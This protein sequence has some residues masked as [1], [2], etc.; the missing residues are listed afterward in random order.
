MQKKSLLVALFC[1]A[2]CLTGCIK[3]EE[4][5]SVAQVRIAKANELNSIADLNKAK[6]AAEAVYAQAELVV[7]QAE[8]KLR[9]AQA[10]LVN[11]QAETEKVRAELLKVKVELREVE[12]DEEKVRLQMLEADLEQKLAEVE[13][14]VAKAEADKQAWVNVLNDLIAKAELQNLRNAKAM[15][16]AEEDLENY[17]LTQ[18]GIK[19]DSAKAYSRRYFAALDE[20]QKLQYEQITTKATKALVEAGALKVRDAIHDE[21]DKIDEQIEENEAIIAILKERQTMTP[22]EAKVAVREAKL[23]LED[24]YTVRAF[25]DSVEAFAEA[26]LATL[27][28]K[29]A[30]Y[31]QGWKR[32][33]KDKF[34]DLD[35]L[36]ESEVYYGGHKTIDGVQYYGVYAYTEEEDEEPEFTPMW[37]T[38]GSY[39]VYGKWAAAETTYQRYPDIHVYEGE[40]KDFVVLTTTE[41]TPAKI[42]FEAVN[43][44]LDALAAEAKAEAAAV[45]KEE[46]EEN[47]PAR[48]SAWEEKIDEY[49]DT[50]D[51]HTKYVNERKAAIATAEK[52]YLDELAA[53]EGLDNA[54]ETAWEAFQEY[55]LVKYDVDRMLFI[56]QHEAQEAYDKAAVALTSAE[57]NLEVAIA[58]VSDE[59]DNVKTAKENEAK[60][61]GEYRKAAA[62]GIPQETINALEAT[63]QHWNPDFDPETASYGTSGNPH[64]WR[65]ENNEVAADTQNDL[66]NAQDSLKLWQDRE[67]DAQMTLWR[68][69]EGVTG[70]AAAQEAYDNAKAKRQ[71]YELKVSTCQTGANNAESMYKQAKKNYDEADK[72]IAAKEIWN[73]GFGEYEKYIVNYDSEAIDTTEYYGLTKAAGNWVRGTE[74]AGTSQAGLV[75]AV[76][77]YR[78]AV[79]DTTETA[80][81]KTHKD[82]YLA[83]KDD[84][85]EAKEALDAANAAL[86]AAIKATTNKT[87]DKIEDYLDEKAIALWDAYQAAIKEA[88]DKEHKAWSNLIKLYA[89]NPNHIGEYDDEDIE[90]LWRRLFRAQFS[91]VKSSYN[92]DYTAQI[93]CPD[94]EYHYIAEMLNEVDLTDEDEPVFTASHSLAYQIEKLQSVIDA[95]DEYLEWFEGKV[96]D[97][98][99]DVLDDIEEV[100]EGVMPYKALESSY[101]DWIDEIGK[102]ENGLNELKKAA[103]DADKEYKTAKAVYEGVKYIADGFVYV[104]VGE[105]VSGADEEGFMKLNINQAI[106]QLE[107]SNMDLRTIV[108]GLM[109]VVMLAND[110]DD[111]D[112]DRYDSDP[113]NNALV[114]IPAVEAHATGFGFG[115]MSIAELQFTKEL[116]QDAL[117]YGKI[118]LQYVL[119]SYDEELAKIEEEI[120]FWAILANKYK[121]IMNT[122]L[123]IVDDTVVA[124]PVEGDE[125]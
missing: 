16:A 68:T 6:A 46:K 105:G 49:E 78:A 76:I 53:N 39:P 98:L 25:A 42:D 86:I 1:G 9:E 51:L 34:K 63:R 88:G 90:D 62:T 37:T 5:A 89:F 104:Y 106:K 23:A 107:G 85:A 70:H 47:I 102:A 95:K 35:A 52:A 60:G 32:E 58:L 67:Y 87:S 80:G 110:D 75:D 99:Q 118:A 79:I 21:I 40:G 109:Q 91:W 115:H 72:A 55:M 113:V 114:R 20:I 97:E 59:K 83:A 30:D 112:D 15:I 10:N 73:P 2:L 13:A 123:G 12:V 18:E 27:T 29:T 57:D 61:Q 43:E 28:S 19:A 121:A 81:G 92:V 93:L 50:L 56:R 33:F 82:K 44:V 36:D 94:G 69:P 65:D 119:E 14:A 100:R 111:D 48:V 64:T 101:L 74:A 54:V 122:Y 96:N 71:A 8:A 31:T 26:N 17:L 24:A 22:E 84:E 4:S 38:L 103:F 11:A 124:E 77:A 108:G 125:E 45:I 3:N 120:D 117:K 116:L 7:A 66:L 41:I